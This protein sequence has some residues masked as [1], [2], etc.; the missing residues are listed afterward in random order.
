M[1]F[2][3][4]VLN[5]L[6]IKD[7]SG[8][9]DDGFEKFLSKPIQRQYQ[10]FGGP[11]P[12]TQ[13]SIAQPQYAPQEPQQ[14]AQPYQNFNDYD[15]DVYEQKKKQFTYVNQDAS[16]HS[17]SAKLYEDRYDDFV[18]T[19]FRPYY[20]SLGGFDGDFETD[21]DYA[22]AIE[23][24]YKGDLTLSQSEDGF[25]GESDEKKAARERLKG[26]TQWNSP[27]GLRDQ[28]QR[29]KQEKEMRRALA[30]RSSAQ[31]TALMDQMTMLPRMQLDD[32]L[33]A[34]KS[35]SSSKPRSRKATNEMLDQM[36]F[37]DPGMVNP[38]TGLRSN[39]Y[40]TD[41]RN[42]IKGMVNPETGKRSKDFYA[43]QDRM[44]A[45][46]R[47]DMAGFMTRRESVAKDRQMR[48]RGMLFSQNGMLDGYPVGMSRMDTDILDIEKARKMGIKEY[49]GRPIEEAFN[50][51][52]GEERLNVAKIMNAVRSAY[53][54][55]EKAQI[56]WL[57]GNRKEDLKAPMEE[58]NDSFEKALQLAA[59]FGLTDEIVEQT[60]SKGFF[61]RMADSMKNAFSRGMKMNEMSK[62]ADD[63]FLNAADQSEIEKFIQAAEELGEIPTSSAANKFQNYKS[64][65]LWDS[66]S[67]LLF[68][69]TEAIPELFV[70]SMSSF[71]PA[72]VRTGM[73]TIPGG[74]AAGGA[75]GLAGG[76]LAPVTV[77]GGAV[78]GAGIAARLNWGTASMVLEYSGMVLQGM[79]E[80]NIDWQ[81]PKVFAAAW[82]N[83]IT[84]DAIKDKALKKGL[85]IALLDAFSGMMAGKVSAALHHGG[86]AI[87]GGKLIDGAAWK[88][89]KQTY[90]RFTNFQRGTNIGLEIGADATAGMGGEFLGQ[91]WSKEPGEAW[92][93]NAI[94]AEGIIG[95]GPG[96]LG[97]AYEFAAKPNVSFEGT[98]FDYE[99]V[100]NTQTG[101][102]GTVNLAGF[103]NQ[104]HSFNDAR[105]AAAHVLNEGNYANAEAKDNATRVLTDIMGR[106]YAINPDA[107]KDLKIVVAD[108][109][110]YA[111]KEM[112]GSYHFDNETQ[113]SVIYINR[114][115]IGQDPLGVFLHEAGHLARH[116][117][118]DKA[119]LISKYDSIGP[120]AQNDAFAQYTLKIP[121]IKY[122][123]LD[124]A[125]KAQVDK[126]KNSKDMSKLRMAEE[127]FSYQWANLLAGHKVD[128]SVKTEYQNF[129]TNVIHPA[130]EKFIGGETTGGSKKDKFE[131]DQ[132]ILRKMGFNPDGTPKEG[133]KFGQYYQE[134]AGMAERFFG[135]DMPIQQM[136]DEEALNHL[137]RKVAVIAQTEG[138]ARA[139]QVAEATNKIL[140]KKILPTEMSAYTNLELQEAITPLGE[141]QIDAQDAVATAEVL[142]T[143]EGKDAEAG[144][145]ELVEEVEVDGDTSTNVTETAELEKTLKKAELELQTA[146]TEFDSAKRAGQPKEQKSAGKRVVRAKQTIKGTKAA[147]EKAKNLPAKAKGQ[148][149]KVARVQKDIDKAVDQTAEQINQAQALMPGAEVTQKGDKFELRTRQPGTRKA[150]SA[151]TFDTKEAAEKAKEDFYKAELK[152]LKDTSQAVTNLKKLVLNEKEFEKEAAK[153]KAKLFKELQSKQRKDSKKELTEEDITFGQII[154]EMMDLNGLQANAIFSSALAGDRLSELG[155]MKAPDGQRVVQIFE[156]Y[157]QKVES[158]SFLIGQR[159]VDLEK[160]KEAILNPEALGSAQAKEYKY[161]HK[162]VVVVNRAGNK[163]QY[164]EWDGS[165]FGPQKEAERSAKGAKGKKEGDFIQK[166]NAKSHRY[167]SKE[168]AKAKAAAAKEKGIDPKYIQYKQNKAEGS[169]PAKKAPAKPAAKAKAEPEKSEKSE[170]KELT[171][172]QKAE[173]TEINKKITMLKQYLDAIQPEKAAIDWKDTPH[174]TYHKYIGPKEEMSFKEENFE[175]YTL[176]ELASTQR[177]DD[178]IWQ[179][180]WNKKRNRHEF[181]QVKGVSDTQDYLFKYT[182]WR[183]NEQEQAAKPEPKAE[184]QKPKAKEKAETE[185]A[186]EPEAKAVDEEKEDVA[187]DPI[188]IL[189]AKA[190][191]KSR[192]EVSDYNGLKQTAKGG[193]SSDEALD[194]LISNG[195]ELEKAL[196]ARLKK[197]G[198][199]K[200]VRVGVI[201]E[202]SDQIDRGAYFYNKQKNADP[203]GVVV[204]PGGT[205][206][207]ILH[208]MMHAITVVES[209]NYTKEKRTPVFS[210]ENM[211]RLYG[212]WKKARKGW[213]SDK[214][215]RPNKDSYGNSISEKQVPFYLTQFDEFLAMLYTDKELQKFLSKIET[216][217]PVKE[218]LFTEILD[219]LSK[220]L[221]FDPTGRTLLE[222]SLN[223]LDSFVKSQ[224]EQQDPTSLGSGLANPDQSQA[225]NPFINGRKLTD[226][227]EWFGNKTVQE[228]IDLL[229]A[230]RASAAMPENVGE[231]AIGKAVK[232][233][234]KEVGQKDRIYFQPQKG[235]TVAAMMLFRLKEMDRK[236]GVNS[237]Q[238]INGNLDR[239]T[240][241]EMTV[242]ELATG[243]AMEILDDR[244]FSGYKQQR[245]HQVI[246]RKASEMAKDIEAYEKLLAKTDDPKE[247]AGIEKALND[248]RRQL[249]GLI[250]D[251]D[252]I[253]AFQGE[254][255]GGAFAKIHAGSM[256]WTE[257]L[258][259]FMF[260]REKADA[261]QTIL[262]IWEDDI[263]N[264]QGPGMGRKPK[265]RRNA[266]EQGA[267]D[268]WLIYQALKRSPD[269]TREQ[270]EASLAEF[271]KKAEEAKG[272]FEEAYAEKA[273]IEETQAAKAWGTETV[274]PDDYVFFGP[275][276]KATSKVKETS[277]H[278]SFAR[279]AVDEGI[280]VL[281]MFGKGRA[282]NFNPEKT[283]FGT[284]SG[285]EQANIGLAADLDR[286]VNEQI[287]KKLR[288]LLKRKESQNIDAFEI[289]KPDGKTLKVKR[290]NGAWKKGN[291]TKLSKD[292]QKIAE[293]TYINSRI[294][295][296][297]SVN[298][299]IENM[300]ADAIAGV[301]S[302][303]H[304]SAVQ[305]VEYLIAQVK[306]KGGGKDALKKVMRSLE[307]NPSSETKDGIVK[308]LP[309]G[310]AGGLL[311]YVWFE[312]ITA[313][314]KKL[315]IKTEL[316]LTEASDP[317]KSGWKNIADEMI[318][319]VS[320]NEKGEQVDPSKLSKDEKKK[321]RQIRISEKNDLYKDGIP[322]MDVMVEM[323]K[324]I[325]QAV[326][327][328]G[329]LRLNPG[330][331]FDETESN[332]NS[333]NASNILQR[334][335]LLHENPLDSV[336]GYE[337]APEGS[338]D[339][340]ETDSATNKDQA[341]QTADDLEP[342]AIGNLREFEKEELESGVQSTELSDEQL[343]KFDD[344]NKRLTRIRTKRGVSFEKVFKEFKEEPT[345]W[346]VYGLPA[347]TKPYP[348]W[349]K[350]IKDH[351]KFPEFKRIILDPDSNPEGSGP[352]GGGQK[353]KQFLFEDMLKNRGDLSY[354]LGSS[355]S[356]SS[357]VSTDALKTSTVLTRMANK[358]GLDDEGK[359]ALKDYFAKKK[360]DLKSGDII[361]SFVDQ[362]R[363]GTKFISDALRNMGIE[364]QALLDQLDVRGL[365][366]QYYGKTDEQ[367]KQAE[368]RFIE[369]I[370]D[371]LSDHGISQEEFGEYLIARMA[372]SRN[373]HLK[374][375]Y[376][377]MMNELDDGDK[378]NS[379]KEMLEKRGDNLSGVATD[380]AIKVVKKM[381]AEPAFLNFLQDSRE[382][383]Q[384]F[385]DM[386][387]EGL[388]HRAESELIRSSGD[389]NEAKAMRLASS[390]FNWKKDGGSKFSFKNNGKDD[391]YSYAP[392][393]GF[394]GGTD[395]LYEKEEAYGVVGKSSSSSGRAWDQPKNKFLFKGAFGRP[396]DSVGPNP[397]TVFAVARQQ[398]FEGGVRGAKNEVSNSFGAAFEL[399][400]AVAYHGKEITEGEPLAPLPPAVLE[401]IEKDPSIIETARE[402]F[403]GK[404]AIFEKDFKQIDIKKDYEIVEKDILVDGKK[405]E[406]LRM[407][408]R[409]INTEFQNDPYVFVYRKNGVPYYVQFKKDANGGRVARS[410]KNLRYEALPAFL[411]GVN[412]VTRFMASM[413]TS[414]NP[415]FIIP[416]FI[417][418]LGT[419]FIHLS[420]DDKKKFIKATFSPKRLKGFM[421]ETMKVERK[422]YKGEIV[423]LDPK[424]LSTEE[425]A[426]KLIREGD[427]QRVY[428]LAKEAGAK[429]GYFRAKSVPE[430]LEEME[431]YDTKSKKGMRGAWNSFVNLLDVTNTGVENSIR[432]SAFASAVEAGY[433]VHQAATISRNVTVDFNQKG[434]MTQTMGS[435]FVFFGASMNSMHR[436]MSTFKKRSPA[437]RKKLIL[438]I[439]GASFGLS[440][441]NRIMDDDEDEPIPD[442]DT[443]S[444][445][446]RD[447]M[448]IVGDPRDKNTGYVGIPLPLGYNM[449]WAL[450]QTAGDFFAKTVMGRGGAGPV[451]FLTRNL[452]ATLNAFNPIGGSTLATAMIPTVGKP[453]AE[454]WA[455]QN[456]MGMPIRNE[457]R[458]YEAPKP[459]HMMDPKRT[460]EHWTALSEGLNNLLGGSD[461]VKGSVGGL[462]GGSPLNNLEGTDMKFDISGSQMEHLL[463]GYA[464]GPGQIANAMFGGLLF[465]AMSEEKD[466]GKFDPNKMPIANRFYRSTTH[467]SRVK[468]LYYQVREANK[469]AD[470]AIK[471]A[472]IAGPK[473]FNEAQK[474]LK[475]LLALSSNIKYADAFKKKVAAQKSKVEVSKSLTQDQ[476]LQRIAQLEQREHDAYVKVIKKAQ[477]LGIS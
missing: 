191:I 291:N 247:K 400:R 109:T 315:K 350:T 439:A 436:M 102:T 159:I 459:A 84:R 193:I 131:F 160:R 431:K 443:I 419:A 468:N 319:T 466:Y 257:I 369:P 70:E 43:Q 411:K 206:L 145:N 110:P 384:K 376:T 399:F 162:I 348:K 137:M 10:P 118:M 207:T 452:N 22:S 181:V 256:K 446:R 151:K 14:Q 397:E 346:E 402:M 41:P 64:K 79:Q 121:E 169:A 133:P 364:D 182:N 347:P 375:M 334:D 188:S 231:R 360:D 367:V 361:S 311:P 94:A 356:L 149:V 381:E 140:G 470:R 283:T 127:W 21:D 40:R 67:N 355:Y 92:D 465:P 412:S 464:G 335:P 244:E 178:T 418:D 393:Q 435:L 197:A 313:L 227:L 273:A 440:I 105:P 351:P 286:K 262:D 378:K 19:K 187:S 377:E 216:D 252:E 294:D 150:G 241:S 134:R 12:Q 474:N 192:T 318:R 382:P 333:A 5:D 371:A 53:S 395:T 209:T 89:S 147:I 15:L 60:E 451:D 341:K 281:S 263:A 353:Q 372:P 342:E 113:T 30:D 222:E 477:S 279:G 124:D 214:T 331:G 467:G 72:Y 115:K 52:G 154:A 280:P 460:Q 203:G 420:E 285:S 306:K 174:M 114:N 250:F 388:N 299:D 71:L 120:D 453:V 362:S 224:S 396:E 200:K 290:V 327:N 301:S 387:L 75:A 44:A 352:K 322:D 354:G 450:G 8:E 274:A 469:I 85:P 170:K 119:E 424:G 308:Q 33:K 50:E 74:A 230:V 213:Q 326:Y 255:T 405:V 340:A 132:M 249:K 117:M 221:K 444:S 423:Q 248:L 28:F 183:L 312:F 421:F 205:G 73:Y 223:A 179:K 38:E 155:S 198:V 111:D 368:M 45:A 177:E 415:A 211:Q 25:F 195:T 277:A 3:D 190:P 314:H 373:I 265:E 220:I 166:Y 242:Y 461:E 316:K 210:N 296:I 189:K 475:G 24:M 243:R 237:R 36:Q 62:Y 135:N 82:N 93:T 103:R 357:G 112:E 321:V 99:G 447:T 329:R 295:V 104:F 232:S 173:L 47:G 235:T 458:P 158:A 176:G 259:E 152:K 212:A 254:E 363:A 78:S 328:S 282:D 432:M 90:P 343:D 202:V 426:K 180:I 302:G 98:P 366:H 161:T 398:Y 138:E 76:P 56:D 146:Q 289:T 258:T 229:D 293:D 23:D 236:S 379:L 204:Y 31:K 20:Q 428:Q 260:Y 54:N 413:F 186:P 332:A 300:D 449:F 275:G 106:L 336:L 394:E 304:V 472:K 245:Y 337:E 141:A 391:N 172:E 339:N 414:R 392:M 185:A 324:P 267:I 251:Y 463:L 58:A 473:E 407:V 401:R 292:L 69:N 88:R 403:E 427:Y 96:L 2:D 122:S 287:Q 97:G 168:Y 80:L 87:K 157:E 136:G 278:G 462:F 51:L 123:Q 261:V 317:A 320:V 271:R 61:S 42:K 228:Y 18:K 246:E 4:S 29:L 68:D 434:E 95:L 404:D 380:I 422:A 34:R 303:A 37:E 270:I 385:Y 86:N 9:K 144:V 325:I 175:R 208:E 416:N 129:L 390:F 156:E 268:S 81:N 218:S 153:V 165:K 349:L 35:A 386:N 226:K 365:W 323:V 32:A 269:V 13:S 238:L 196:A 442:Y 457:D 284:G 171:K 107:M 16:A 130:M 305:L 128:P 116:L 63:F 408:T 219:L 406:G 429:V 266:P 448:A 83:Q 437:E 430:L 65:G 445:Y 100:A 383:L 164:R 46:M 297:D 417:R 126:A 438:T 184:G 370:M 77:T 239:V 125:Q 66:I 163:I 167:L 142:E 143:L 199:L 11:K 217:T 330:R 233:E 201:D 288:N 471:A 456:F 194:I 27:N 108:R 307:W 7:N 91:A 148:K 454:L 272:K 309:G 455:N 26:F 1:S 6:G 225:F 59:Q 17:A 240:L 49:K 410:I 55:R 338:F 298:K 433:T 253:G 358:V 425:Y 310:P 264:D 57:A 215:I 441:F 48:D 359:K 139:K 39:L 234:G 409:E 374:K 389:I 101:Q 476:K 345:F 344:I 276:E